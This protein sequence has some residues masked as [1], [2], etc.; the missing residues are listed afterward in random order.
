[1]SVYKSLIARKEAENKESMGASM[2]KRLFVADI[3]NRDPEFG[4]VIL[5][6]D[7]YR[8]HRPSNNNRKNTL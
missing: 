1:M 5:D 6:E 4:G 7:D 3:A 8:S 2:N